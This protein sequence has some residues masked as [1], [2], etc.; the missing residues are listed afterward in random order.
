MRTA[1]PT[2][3]ILRYL[4][5]LTIFGKTYKLRSS[6]LCSFLQ[7]S[8]TSFL[9]G[10]YILLSTLFSNTLNLCFSRNVGDEASNPYK[11]PGKIIFLHVS[12][13]TLLGWR[14]K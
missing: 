9:A 7:P 11:T 3:L 10:L 2:H 8:V 1:C 14:Q 13:L 6:L 5:A 12:V 4:I